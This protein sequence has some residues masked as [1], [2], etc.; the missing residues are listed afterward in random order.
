MLVQGNRYNFLAK[1]YFTKS[2]KSYVIPD[3]KDTTIAKVLVNTSQCCFGV[4]HE[5]HT[6]QVRN[7]E[8]TILA[9]CCKLLGIMKIRTTSFH[10]QSDRMVGRFNQTLC[11]KL[12]KQCIEGQS[13]WGE[14]R[15]ALLMVYRPA[16]HKT[17]G[18]IIDLLTG[19]PSGEGLSTD[20]PG[21]ARE[22]NELM[23]EVYHQV[24]DA[25]KISGR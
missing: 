4:P 25:L 20:I 7:S 2:P 21:F 11:Q 17:K 5:F 13:A 14:K 19:K 10:L 9:E 15:P 23:E 16:A 22:L 18:G 24:Q 12:A 8:S 6:H 1:D 3:Q